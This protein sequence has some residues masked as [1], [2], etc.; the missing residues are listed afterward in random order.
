MKMKE[1][2]NVGAIAGTGDA[3]LAPD[4]REPG[5]RKGKFAGNSTFMFKRQQ[6]L[7]FQNLSKKDRK[8]WKKYLG[9]NEDYIMP[10]REFA[11]K[12][13]KSPIIFEDEDTGHLFY[14]KYGKK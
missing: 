13:P 12:N 9:K 1:E 14:A 11:K 2:T 10:V 3:R 5:V 6:F 8:W 4:Q 7:E